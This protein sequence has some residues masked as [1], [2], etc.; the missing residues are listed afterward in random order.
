MVG[1]AMAAT[2]WRDDRVQAARGLQRMRR[3]ETLR[4]A[5]RD[6]LDLD[7]VVL[8]EVARA[9][10]HWGGVQVAAHAVG[11][12][13]TSGSVVLLGQ[14]VRNLLD[15]AARHAQS[16]V[17]VGLDEH[18]GVVELRVGDDGTG[19]ATDDRARVYERFERLDEARARDECGSGLGLA[20]VRKIVETCGGSVEVADSEAGG[21]LFVVRLPRALD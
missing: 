7:D 8:T 19:I 13:Q 17:T 1:R 20:I 14:V 18:D 6:V 16:T 9:R 5:A 2:T 10:E 15:N 4:A 21:A 12:G 11:A 3:T